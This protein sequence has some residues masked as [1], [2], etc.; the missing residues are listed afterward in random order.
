MNVVIKGMKMP[1]TCGECR[2]CRPKGPY[3]CNCYAGDFLVKPSETDMKDGMCPLELVF[4]M[5]EL[6]KMAHDYCAECLHVEVCSWYPMDGCEFRDVSIENK[7]EKQ[8]GQDE[9]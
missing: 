2:F 6:Y 5:D 4:D 1:K 7:R 8:N 3:P 9:S